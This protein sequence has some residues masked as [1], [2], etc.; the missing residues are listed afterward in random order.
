MQSSGTELMKV[1][2]TK[3][4]FIVYLYVTL[5]ETDWKVIAVDVNDQ[6]APT[7]NGK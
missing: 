2:C 7:L 3:K 5:G 1:T 6:L 4:Q